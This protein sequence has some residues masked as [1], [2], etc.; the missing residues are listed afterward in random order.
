MTLY[1]RGDHDWSKYSDHCTECSLP[2]S[3]WDKPC[4]PSTDDSPEARAEIKEIAD[5]TAGQ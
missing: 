1:Q 5:A 4:V 2:I 3:A